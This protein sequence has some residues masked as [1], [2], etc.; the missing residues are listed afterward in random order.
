[1]KES[2][3]I[4]MQIYECSKKIRSDDIDHINHTTILFRSFLNKIYIE[5]IY[6]FVF[7][8]SFVI[9]YFFEML[10]YFLH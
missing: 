9:Y 1:M 3:E 2:H 6:L 4:I 8:M 5:I 10:K 7:F